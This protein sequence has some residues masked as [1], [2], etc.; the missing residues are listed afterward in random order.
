MNIVGLIIQTQ[1]MR[2]EKPID[3]PKVAQGRFQSNA[4]RRGR[5]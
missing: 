4:T 5:N 2:K 3:M 1:S